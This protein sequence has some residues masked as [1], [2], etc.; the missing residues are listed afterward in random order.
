MRRIRDPPSAVDAESIHVEIHTF[1]RRSMDLFSS[2]DNLCIG[3][4]GLDQL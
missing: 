4:D 1:V 2:A 3:A